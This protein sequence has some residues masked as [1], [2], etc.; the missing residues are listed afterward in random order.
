M[1]RPPKE[2]LRALSED[3]QEYL[4][5][6]S[7]SQ[8]AP[9]IQVTRAKLLLAV[10]GGLGY[11][12]AA[13]SVGRKDGDP[14]SKLVHRFNR[15]GLDALVPKYGGGREPIYGP[16]ERERILR[17]FRRPPTLEQDGTTCWSLSSLQHAL[18]SAD[19][20]LP[21]ISTQTIWKVLREAGYRFQ[22]DRSW[23]QTGVVRRK[24][25]AGVV[26][27]QDPLAELKKTD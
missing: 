26:V 10:S 23:C 12:Q 8:S 7:R 20:G 19:D 17:E 4:G 16:D 9:N 13:R 5:M 27:V 14:V 21:K 18:R 22:K 15:E 1:G 3:E 11:L 24:R 25:K 6:L 2:R